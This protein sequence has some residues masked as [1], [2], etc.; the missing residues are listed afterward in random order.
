MRDIV[1][2]VILIVLGLLFGNSIFQGHFGVM[3]IF[4]DGL[5]L[6]FI[7]KGLI[8]IIRSRQQSGA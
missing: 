5:G 4:F 8:R 7:V 1:T 3:S 2:G 6:F